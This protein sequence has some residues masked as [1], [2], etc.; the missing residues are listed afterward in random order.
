MDIL[1]ENITDE[2]VD[3]NVDSDSAALTVT[4]T[5]PAA[6]FTTSGNSP[7]VTISNTGVGSALAT[8]GAIEV[9]SISS[10]ESIRCEG[11]ISSTGTLSGHTI[12]IADVKIGKDELQTLQALHAGQLKI[13]LTTGSGYQLYDSDAK[14]DGKPEKEGWYAL[15]SNSPSDMSNY[16]SNEWTVAITSNQLTTQAVSLLAKNNISS[17]QDID[18]QALVLQ[19]AAL[20]KTN[21]ELLNRISVLENKQL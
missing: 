4:N 9:G 10:Q 8:D 15:T 3:I 14:R 2:P 20:I 6:S 1:L 16:A 12:E 18:M 11:D 21:E 5:G 17:S 7:T 19:V 13:N